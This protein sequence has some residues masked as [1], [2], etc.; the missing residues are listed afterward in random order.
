MRIRKKLIVLHTF[1]SMALAATLIM[2]VSPLVMR[3]V[4]EAEAAEARL[5]LGTMRVALGDDAS[6]LA[7]AGTRER[8]DQLSRSLPKGVRVGVRAGDGQGLLNLPEP[9]PGPPGGFVADRDQPERGIIVGRLPTGEAAVFW[10]ADGLS[11]LQVSVRLDT[12]RAAIDRFILILALVLLAVYALIAI[13]LEVFVLP[14][15]VYRP[16]HDILHADAAV[17]SGQ[18][19]QELIPPQRIPADELGEIMRSR[20][21]VVS[22]LREQEQRLDRTMNE[23]AATATDLQTKNGLLEAAQRNLADADRLASLGIMSAGLAHE[24]NTPL[25]V[26]KG[27]GEKLERQSGSL[28]AS[29]AALM[30][31]VIARLERLSESLLDFARVRP[32]KLAPVALGPLVDEAWTLVRL[33]REARG[34]E[35]ISD[36]D[37]ALTVSA[38]GDRLMQVMVNLL[39]NAV[40]AMTS[41]PAS[42]ATTPGRG[43][44]SWS[45][46]NRSHIRVS[47]GPVESQGRRWVRIVVADSGPGIAPQVLAHLFEPFAST[48]LDSRGTG[49]GLAVSQGIIRE[50]A[51]VM[52]ARNRADGRGAEFEILLPCD[53]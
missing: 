39:R 51:G 2:V 28:D 6:V 37:P 42:A 22:A 1:F 53:A 10:P 11:Q 31:R 50:H 47:A 3:V 41:A 52:S 48:R 17:Q 9:V 49:L 15:H 35:L 18:R 25:A 14:A 4:L 5:T 20:N 38:D 34:L 19:S 32:P 13:T 24:M 29:D 7:E 21:A 30:Q 27:L 44:E 33:D 46:D 40:D 12:A 36:I 8:I 16:I 26:I 45:S 23:L 43:F